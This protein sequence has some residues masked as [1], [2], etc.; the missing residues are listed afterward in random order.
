MCERGFC[1]SPSGG[2]TPFRAQFGLLRL[3]GASGALSPRAAR[4]PADHP[5]SHQGLRAN[6]GCCDFEVVIFLALQTQAV[7][8][9]VL[10]VRGAFAESG[11]LDSVCFTLVPVEE[12][13]L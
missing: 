2:W 7:V 3:S 11:L 9:S 12:A 6:I 8:P 4:V 10:A 1:N 13:T 5:D